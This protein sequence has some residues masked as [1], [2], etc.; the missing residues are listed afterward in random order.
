MI[1]VLQK[2]QKMEKHRDTWPASQTLMRKLDI[3]GRTGRLDKTQDM[4]LSEDEE[5]EAS[6]ISA[7]AA[8]SVKA[9]YFSL[10]RV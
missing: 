3:N 2:S 7:H 8:S 4:L 5:G 6:D 1:I 9:R 10:E